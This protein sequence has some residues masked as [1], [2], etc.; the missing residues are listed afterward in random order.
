MHIKFLPHSRG[1]GSDAI[2]YLLGELDHRMRPRAEVRVLRGNP[3]LTGALIDALPNIHRYSSGVISWH[4]DDEPTDD[5]IR[6]VLDDV[7]RMAFAGL[8]RDQYDLCAV[9]HVE[10]DGS[11]HVHFVAPR[12]EL[13]S[14]KALNISPP[15]WRWWTDPI[16]DYWNW[17]K[18]WA[19][20]D[21]PLRARPVQP[22][23][24]AAASA[25]TPAASPDNDPNPK[26]VLAAAVLE[27]VKAGKVRSRA[28]VLAVLRGFGEINRDGDDY[29][30]V[31]LASRA[32]P[33]RLKGLL[34]VRD[35]DVAA[36]L[37]S[38]A[39]PGNRR[40]G[41]EP[42]DLLRAEEARQ[43][44]ERREASRARYN[45]GRYPLAAPAPRPRRG[46]SKPAVDLEHSVELNERPL[47]VRHDQG[48][49]TNT[50]LVLA[51]P[52]PPAPAAKPEVTHDRDRDA[53]GREVQAAFAAA[54]TAVRRLVDAARSAI[55]AAHRLV[56]SIRSLD[57]ATRRIDCSVAG[58]TPLRPRPKDSSAP[59][60]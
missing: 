37:R 10:E 14:G 43:E 54:R 34:F 21:D 7:E 30:S 41:R 4:V 44:M 42:P 53:V 22:G 6:Q 24:M 32:K 60:P 55:E 38:V 52:G 56:G 5:E 23:R 36:V 17:S 39:S 26:V 59:R 18:G 11:R 28:D 31:R 20:P 33:V 13:T 3:W 8:Q 49:Q 57:Q 29:V 2:V 45:R 16:R 58:L 12:V 48:Y 50:D 9:L 19:R 51:P 47:P 25:A 40:S 35:L 46:K 15:A 27:G 1:A